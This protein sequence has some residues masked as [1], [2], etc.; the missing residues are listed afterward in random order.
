[1]AAN[2]FLGANVFVGAQSLEGGNGGIARL[3]RLTARV[4]GEE[5]AAGRLT[6]RGLVYGDPDAAPEFGFPV[7]TARRS[8][9]RFVLEAHRAALSCSHFVYDFLGMAR[10]HCRFPLLRRPF[11][12]WLCGID[13]W[14]DAPPVRVRTARRADYP[15]FISD[16][17]RQRAEHRFDRHAETQELVISAGQPGD[18]ETDR[19][20]VAREPS[21]NA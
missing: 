20:A 9:A 2:L 4:V 14:E 17:S 16:Y 6:A 3:A 19:Q 10:A 1:M 7:R 13:I 11:L 18:L 15:V 21:R 12:T 5:A 8:R